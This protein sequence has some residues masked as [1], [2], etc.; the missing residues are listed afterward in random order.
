MKACIE[1]GIILSPT[2]REW[3]MVE[4]TWTLLEVIFPFVAD[5]KSSRWIC[6][7]E[8][9]GFFILMLG[10]GGLGDGWWWIKVY[11]VVSDGGFRTEWLKKMKGL[12][13]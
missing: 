8:V 3:K 7:R 5:Y 6:E 9:E 10:G 12:G 4:R 2:S 1:E 11:S 13:I